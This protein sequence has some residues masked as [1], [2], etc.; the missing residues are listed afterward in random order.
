MIE[1][2]KSRSNT[3]N[4]STT[5]IKDS[6][7]KK[8]T[9]ATYTD[10]RVAS[11]VDFARQIKGGA[12]TINICNCYTIRIYTHYW[13][14]QIPVALTNIT[15]LIVWLYCENIILEL[16]FLAVAPV[17]IAALVR[18][19]LFLWL[20]YWTLKYCCCCTKYVTYHFSR[21]ADCIGGLHS[22]FGVTALAWNII[23]VFDL[24][25]I[26]NYIFDV[27]TL[28]GLCLPILLLLV[29]TS[30]LP[31]FR[32]HYHNAFELIHRYINWISV[33]TLITHIYFMNTHAFNDLFYMTCNTP[34]LLAIGLVIITLYPWLIIHRIKTKNIEIYPS[35][36]GKTTAFVFPIWSPM[37]AVCKLSI[38]WMEFHVFGITPLPQ[39]DSNSNRYRSLI[40]IK[41]LGDWTKDLCLKAKLQTLNG[42]NFWIHR[43][44]S[45][46]FTQGLFN[47]NKVFIIATGAGIAP[48]LPYVV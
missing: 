45:P 44:K 20:I 5:L 32:H 18:D 28:T 12:L 43:V 30:A 39:T 29:C 3:I 34:S 37:G 16:G 22:S 38:N 13:I 17:F 25:S 46:N 9:N 40:L 15:L 7:T 11:T 42:T 24:F 41:S 26:E 4:H 33:S 10:S 21:L 8:K 6:T 27:R 2:S 19:K 14:W 31:C 47:W 1:F 48:L 35:E 23:Y 36:T